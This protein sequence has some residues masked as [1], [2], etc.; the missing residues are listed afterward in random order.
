MAYGISSQRPPKMRPTPAAADTIS[1]VPDSD[2]Q[3]AQDIAAKTA[4]ALDK[5]Q[6]GLAM[7][8]AGVFER[9]PLINTGHDQQDTTNNITGA[10]QRRREQRGA[11]KRPLCAGGGKRKSEPYEQIT[12]CKPPGR[13]ERFGIDGSLT[14]NTCIEENHRGG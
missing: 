10:F 7:R 11:F 6:G 12:G 1:A 4:V 8:Q 13:G 3:S 2:L 14:A 9:R 5:I